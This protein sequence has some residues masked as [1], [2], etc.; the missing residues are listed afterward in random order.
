MREYKMSVRRTNGLEIWFV[1]A[2]SIY[3]QHRYGWTLFTRWD[4]RQRGFWTNH[5]DPFRRALKCHRYL[6]MGIITRLATL[7]E[8][9]ILGV[10]GLPERVQK[11]HIREI[12]E[13]GRNRNNEKFTEDYK[14]Y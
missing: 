3:V 14:R 4:V 9:S 6:D 2:R 10:G 8:I 11:A 1:D 5:W 12:P 7:H 13:K